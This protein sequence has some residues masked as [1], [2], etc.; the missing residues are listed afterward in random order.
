[1]ARVV[2][3]SII[4]RSDTRRTLPNISE[5]SP[6][7]H[8]LS[9]PVVNSSSDRSSR[10][11]FRTTRWSLVQQAL[12]ATTADDVRLALA[13]LCEA[14]WLPVY[15]FVRKQ[16]RD[17]HDA[18]DVTQAFFTA[19]LS[20]P[21]LENVQPDRGRFRSFLLAAVKNFLSNERDKARALKR[22]GGITIHSLDWK[23]GEERLRGEPVDHMTPERLFEREWAVALLGRVLEQLQAEQTTQRKQASFAVLRQFLGMDRSRAS[24]STAA[25]S[26]GI[27]EQSARVAAHRLRKRYRE[28]LRE[29]I[30]HT[31]ATAEEIDDELRF[32]F[33]SLQ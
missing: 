15:A 12:C 6:Q 10:R 23:R 27:S 18:Q 9:I 32:L 19:L 29:E 3:A 13:E 17:V 28:L 26:L 14:Y 33:A 8:R 2:H 24:Y 11:R 31:T 4:K 21:C 5:I 7:G 30:G 16:T 25:T 20:K 1:L 22:G